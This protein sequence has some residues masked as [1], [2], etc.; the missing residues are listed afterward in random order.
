MWHVWG[1]SENV[2][3]DVFGVTVD[4][5]QGVAVDEKIILKGT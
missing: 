1:R 4:D 5:V 2:Y 3:R